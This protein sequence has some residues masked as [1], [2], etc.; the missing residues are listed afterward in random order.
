[1]PAPDAKKIKGLCCARSV[2][3]TGNCMV[4]DP[5]VLCDSACNP[6]DAPVTAEEE[7]LYLTYFERKLPQ[8]CRTLR[9][10]VRVQVCR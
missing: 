9:F 2:K 7:S 8:I 10:P 4:H 3:P 1:V 5:G 6:A